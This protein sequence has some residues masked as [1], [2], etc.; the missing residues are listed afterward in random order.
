MAGEN[1]PIIAPGPTRGGR[2]RRLIKYLCFMLI[3]VVSSE[4]SLQLF[5]WIVNGAFLFERAA[6]PIFVADDYRGWSVKPNLDYTHTTNE[7]SVGLHTNSQGF[8]VAQGQG[9]FPVVKDASKYR[10]M[11]LGPSFAFGWAADFED[12]FAAQ[13]EKQ[14]EEA[15]FAGQRDVEVLNAGVPSLPPANNLIWYRNVGRHYRPDLVIQLVHGSMA[16]YNRPTDAYTADANGYLVPSRASRVTQARHTA[17]QFGLVFY[18]WSLYAQFKG[19]LGLQPA[20]DNPP[21]GSIQGQVLAD[22]FD[23]HQPIVAEAIEFFQNLKAAAVADNTRLVVVYF[24]PAYN[25]HRR[26]VNRWVHDGVW[27]VDR[28]IAFNRSFC[29]YLDERGIRCINIDQPLID[30]AHRTEERLY[31]WLDTHW[32]PRGN[33]VAA[34]AVTN[35]L[36]NQQAGLVVP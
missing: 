34:R 31:Y 27:D 6:L 28:Q 12:S 35:Y 11:L 10:V 7:F 36:V 32:T 30:E 15:R 3:L 18:S 19:Y 22:L 16:V 25:V 29:R 4:I 13:L 26:D 14:L 20:Q 17:K 33:R 23:P 9:D 8:R 21:K 24:P 5:Y 2:A 1:R